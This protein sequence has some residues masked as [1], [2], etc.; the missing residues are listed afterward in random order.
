M[1]GREQINEPARFAVGRIG[2]AR[3][4]G[5][6]RVETGRPGRLEGVAEFGVGTPGADV[7]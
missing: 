1:G 3:S 7:G 2:I 5:V 6:L 4:E